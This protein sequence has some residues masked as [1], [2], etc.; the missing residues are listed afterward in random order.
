MSTRPR[1]RTPRR[2]PTA[3]AC[4]PIRG[5]TRPVEFQ[6]ALRAE[7]NGAV[8]IDSRTEIDRSKWGMTW[9]MMG[10]NLDNQATVKETFVD[11]DVP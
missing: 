11:C 4:E 5:A 3:R 8:T 10:A 2:S 7:G 9:A 1:P 6:A